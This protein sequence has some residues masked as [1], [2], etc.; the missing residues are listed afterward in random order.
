LRRYWFSSSSYRDEFDHFVTQHWICH[1]QLRYALVD[2]NC[3]VVKVGPKD[4]NDMR[5]A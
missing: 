2:G 4:A 3:F 1:L 5:I